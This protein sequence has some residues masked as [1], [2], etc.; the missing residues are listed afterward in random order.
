MPVL[1]FGSLFSSCMNYYEYTSVP[2][3]GL[4]MVNGYSEDQSIIYYINE[5]AF[6]PLSYKNISLVSLLTG[7]RNLVIRRIDSPETIID[8]TFSI[9]DNTFYTSFTFA[10]TGKPIHFITVDRTVETL[11]DSAKVRFF[12]IAAVTGKVSLQIENRTSRHFFRNRAVENQVSAT[13]NQNFVLQNSGTVNLSIK[14]EIGN[15][16]ASKESVRLDTA[17]YYSIILLGKEGDPSTPLQIDVI[18]QVVY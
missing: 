10:S 2:I 15:I 14:D 17:Q 12:N 5:R 18:Q 9:E 8:T 4:T 16:I 3:A 6:V 7:K 1:L 11:S 13:A